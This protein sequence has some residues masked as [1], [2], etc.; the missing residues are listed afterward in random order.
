MQPQSRQPSDA[1]LAARVAES[2]KSAR[3][4]R[5]PDPGLPAGYNDGAVNPFDSSY[6]D[7]LPPQEESMRVMYEDPG[8]RD[9]KKRIMKLLKG[10]AGEEDAATPS[11][12]GSRDFDKKA[13]RS[14]RIAG[15]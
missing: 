2:S 1:Q 6:A 8:Q 15:F 11:L 5:K 9:E 4:A 12:N 7:D 14:T 3:M 10:T 13:R